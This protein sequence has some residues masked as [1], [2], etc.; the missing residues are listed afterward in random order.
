[1]HSELSDIFMSRICSVSIPITRSCISWPIGLFAAYLQTTNCLRNC[2]LMANENFRD[3]HRSSVCKL[4][5]GNHLVDVGLIGCFCRS[6]KTSRTCMAA[7][8]ASYYCRPYGP[9]PVIRDMRHDC[10]PLYI[11]VLDLFLIFA[12]IAFY[13]SVSV[14]L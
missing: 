6:V 1:M 7:S 14:K 11:G 8:S 13:H 12:L 10:P 4:S 2:G 5:A 3:L 9:M